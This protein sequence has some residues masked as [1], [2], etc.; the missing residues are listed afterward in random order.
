MHLYSVLSSLGAA[1]SGQFGSLGVSWNSG[2]PLVA[3]PSLPPS[4]YSAPGEQKMA[5]NSHHQMERNQTPDDDLGLYLLENHLELGISAVY[6][7]F[8]QTA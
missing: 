1:G 8:F 5:Q 6:E 2:A 3:T 4:Q 7:T